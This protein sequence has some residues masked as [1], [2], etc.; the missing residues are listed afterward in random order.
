MQIGSAELIICSTCGSE[1]YYE[2]DTCHDAMRLRIGEL[3][4]LLD[5]TN[6]TLEFAL[7]R[8][9]KISAERVKEIEAHRQTT[10]K[11]VALQQ[12]PHATQR[13]ATE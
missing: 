12:N 6:H 7:K 5:V 2:T 9:E 1:H 10:L 3:E 13:S 4:A 11:L 8:L